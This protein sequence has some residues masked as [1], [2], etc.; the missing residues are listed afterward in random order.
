MA[1]SKKELKLEFKR[2]DDKDFT[3]TIPDYKSDL[4]PAQVQ[5]AAQTIITQGS[6]EPD[7]FALASLVSAKTVDTLT[8]ELDIS[9]S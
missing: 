9:E 2:T 3:L 5:T 6:F 7:G 4:Q 8:T 1:E